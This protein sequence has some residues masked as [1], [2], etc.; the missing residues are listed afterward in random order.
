MFNLE[1]YKF[2]LFMMHYDIIVVGAGPAGGQ[3][4]RVLSSKGY[5]V[6][7][8]EQYKS[9]SDNN[10]SSA[11]MTLLPLKKFDIPEKTIGSYWKN[12]FIQSSKKTYKWNSNTNKGV[13]L[14]FGKLRKFL[15]DECIASGGKVLMGHKY[16]RKEV[17]ADG[18][19]VYL[20]NL[21]T[22]KMIALQSKI[23]V[24]ATGPSRK[25]IF[26]HKEEL[27]ELLNAVGLEYLVEVEKEAYK[28]C[29]D[30]LVFFLG[31]V[32]A[33]NGYSWIFPMEEGILKVGAG[34]F[35]SKEEK[36]KKDNLLKDL[37]DKIIK[38]YLQAEKVKIIDI[39]GGTLKYSPGLKDT[40]YKDRVVAIGDTVSTVNPLGGEG[41]QYAM[42]NGEYA[43]VYI[44]KYLN[45]KI[46]NFK[47]YQ[48][49]WRKKYYL[50]WLICESATQRVYKKYSDEKIERRLAY[51]HQ[52]TNIDE[53]I[54]LLFN[55]N[56]NKMFFRLMRTL[57]NKYVLRID[58]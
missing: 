36:L 10:F 1:P 40:Y 41:I 38:E 22:K 18:V 11:G 4:A 9:F 30:S 37:I 39:H 35:N 48:K 13:V 8:V 21:E 24:D 3:C 23:V 26:D 43:A 45:K 25:V 19:T 57:F 20:K 2:L 53:L 52:N 27:P 17:N 16:L 50:K 58:K 51:Y 33:P 32:W 14:D 55:F 34:K 29:K 49:K 7:L 28:K 6:L 56:F 46:T 44:D 54:N 42:E 15:A 5:S 12:I 31:N 47:A